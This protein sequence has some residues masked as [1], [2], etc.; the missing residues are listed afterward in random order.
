VD[1][2]CNEGSEVLRLGFAAEH[3]SP[4]LAAELATVAAEEA[5]HAELAWAVVEWA[6]TDGGPAVAWALSAIPLPRIADPN[7]P[8]RPVDG[9]RL[10]HWGWVPPDVRRR[11]VE[12][13]RADAR[14]RLA[15]TIGGPCRFVR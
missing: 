11:C 2:C 4:E 6:I 10:Q 8:A 5:T 7:A 12:R 9:A 1:G 14:I 13:A 3:A 15:A